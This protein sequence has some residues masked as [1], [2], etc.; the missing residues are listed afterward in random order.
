MT[1]REELSSKQTCKTMLICL[2]VPQSTSHDGE[3]QKI[4]QTKWKGSV[5]YSHVM[6]IGSEGSLVIQMVQEAANPSAA[7]HIAKQLPSLAKS[8][9]NTLK[10]L[11]CAI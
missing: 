3:V 2:L 1:Q 11:T 10:Q 8:L 6:P 5:V 7:Y 9:K 4:M